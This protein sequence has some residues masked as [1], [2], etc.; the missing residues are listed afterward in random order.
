MIRLDQ[1]HRALQRRQTVASRVLRVLSVLRVIFVTNHRAIV[2]PRLYNC[3]VV[4]QI[5]LVWYANRFNVLF[6]VVLDFAV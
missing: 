5:T 6:A 2:P 4:P 1:L 3:S